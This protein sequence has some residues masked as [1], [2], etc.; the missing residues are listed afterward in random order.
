MSELSAN[1]M[2]FS[3]LD[4][5]LL[6]HDSYGWEP[7]RPWLE[8][9][10]RHK[11]PVII[12]TSK[13]AAEVERL[14]YELGLDHLPYIAEN[15]ALIALPANW[16]GHPD[17]PRKIFAADYAF[18]CARLHQLRDNQDF[19]FKGFADMDAAEVAALTG[20]PLHG[21]ALARRREAS[22][23]L[24]WLGD[25]DSLVRFR[26]A[27]T[28]LGLSLTQ[29]GRFYHVMG[30]G[31]SK[32]TAANWIK[33]QYPAKNDNRV[34]TIGLGDGPNDVA[35]LAAM[36]NAVVIKAKGNQLVDLPE[37]YT[38]KLY[39]T[40]NMGPDGW[41]EGLDHFLGDSLSS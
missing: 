5:S 11:I 8:R 21:A 14:Q 31:V 2:I 34:R 10:A 15:G 17:Y 38:G 33:E 29:G 9:L 19:R 37:S 7:A 26:L 24:Q 20:L 22:E 16:H 25:T 41:S 32:G 12:T 39:R 30:G 35:L 18:I 27:L 1:L 13:T 4:G 40:R 28:D 36:D 6:D 23:P 3:D